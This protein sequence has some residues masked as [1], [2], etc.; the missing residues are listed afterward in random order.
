ML[1]GRSDLL[2]LFDEL[3][4]EPRL[5]RTRAHVDVIGGAAMSLAYARNRLTEDV[6]ARFDAGHYRLTQAV[7]TVARRHGLPESW[8][9]EQAVSAIPRSPDGM[10][11]TL[12]STPSLTVTGASPKHL[13]AMKDRDDIRS[14]V[15]LLDIRDPEDGRRIHDR[16]FPGEAIPRS[17][18]E[19]LEEACSGRPPTDSE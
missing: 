2:S 3:S 18:R 8:L 16:L 5:H 14:L 12:Y 9:N 7:R 13:L 19:Y 6:D 17:A 4:R 15:H 10:A 1:L 11:R